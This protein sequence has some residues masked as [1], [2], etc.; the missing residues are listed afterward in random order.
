MGYDYNNKNL[1]TDEFRKIIQT[2]MS[3]QLPNF[4]RTF[5]K[6]QANK[7]FIKIFSELELIE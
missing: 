1:T 2:T 4:R 7:E 5:S 6:S 3:Y